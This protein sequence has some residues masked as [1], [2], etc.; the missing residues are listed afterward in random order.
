[1]GWTVPPPPKKFYV[2]VLTSSTLF[3]DRVFISSQNEF[4]RVGPKKIQLVSL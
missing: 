2:E 3:G 4:I 1:M